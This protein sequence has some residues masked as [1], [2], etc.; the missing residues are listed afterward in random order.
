MKSS[1]F[2]RTVYSLK[3]FLQVDVAVW[4]NLLKEHHLSCMHE[5]A[6]YAQKKAWFDCFNILRSELGRL[7]LNPNL[8]EEVYIVFEYELPRE[9]GRRPDVLLLSG[10]NLLVLEF[11]GFTQE[12]QAQVDQAKHYARDLRSYHQAS[13][14]LQVFPFLVLAAGREVCHKLGGV[15]I[16]SGDQLH[17]KIEPYLNAS[18]PNIRAWFESEYAP[19]PSLLQSAQ[20]LYRENK[21][22]Q[23]KRA[24]SAGIPATLQRLTG[25]LEQSRQSQSYHLALITGVPGAGKTLVG[26]QFVFDTHTQENV[27]QAVF[28]SGNGPLV[29]VL[30]YSLGN[31]NFVQS[32]HGFLKQYAH[33]SQLPS[34][35]V[36]IYDEA[37]RAWDAERVAG[38]RRGSTNAEPMDFVSIGSRK[39]HCLLV[40]LIGEGQEIYLGEESGMGLWHEAI[41]QSDQ[42]WV[43]HCPGKL[44]GIFSGA[45][46]EVVEEF[47][48][49]TSLRTHQTLKLQE[50]VECLLDGDIALASELAKG[51]Q[52]EEYPIYV[53]RNLEQAKNHVREKYQDEPEK[54][55]GLLATSKNKLLPRYGIANDYS[56]TK[57]FSVSHYYV[58]VNH[59]A[60]CRN[61]KSVVT[62]F[63]CQGLELDMP[64]LAWDADFVYDKV[65]KNMAPM[66]KAKDSDRLRKNSY[67]VLLTRGRD[68]LVI[69]VPADS[70]LDSTF[71]ALVQAVGRL[72]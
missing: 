44:A 60:Y 4:G 18:F 53:T 65:W 67:R 63:G 24:N 35:D 61:L 17:S 42:D 49:T 71:E 69:F 34:E 10:D 12:S 39:T 2:D 66:A 7:E 13:H 14:R 9:K 20:L 21:F 59:W 45:R 68:G 36:I 43:I 54:T 31:R 48:L 16:V 51:L 46:V 15:H 62:E 22:P 58:D 40:G 52:A 23:I 8:Q 50:W 55:Y 64:V 32:V 38:S 25:L 57:S 41:S 47:N 1:Q 72:L 26:L 19:L 27:Q 37:Q 5:P 6:S 56:S 28:L 70:R 29:D 11:K 30:Q 3:S 33:G